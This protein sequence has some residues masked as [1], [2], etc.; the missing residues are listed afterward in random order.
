MMSLLGIAA[1]VI[2]FMLIRSREWGGALVFFLVGVVLL[3]DESR[4][5]NWAAALPG[6]FA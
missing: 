6:T 5:I 2:A 1:I 3:D 4:F